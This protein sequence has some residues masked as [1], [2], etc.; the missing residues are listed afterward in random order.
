MPM[1][2]RLSRVSFAEQSAKDS[3]ATAGQFRVGVSTG[4]I[5]QFGT[6]NNPLPSTWD[7]RITDATERTQAMP[8]GAFTVITMK[9]TIGAI[10][11]GL[12]GSHAVAGADPY[13]HTFSLANTLPYY[14]IFAEYDIGGQAE[15]H[16]MEN[17]KF[18]SGEF[19]WAERGA[20]MCALDVMGSAISFDQGP[21]SPTDERSSGGYFK[22]VGGSLN[23]DGASARVKSGGITIANELTEVIDGTKVLPDDVFEGM[24]GINVS[25]TVVPDNMDLWRKHLTGSASGTSVQDTPYEGSLDVTFADVETTTYSLRFDIDKMPFMAA[26]PASDPSGG[27]AEIVVEG[28]AIGDDNSSAISVVLINDE[29]DYTS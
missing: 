7:S 21:G 27:P 19:S 10:L 16:R 22:S 26:F 28:V 6:D 1:N 14:S 18:N 29:S 15:Q 11:K 17:M 12:L 25:L 9:K 20:L 23:I 5:I 24:V 8:H 3:A 2:R 4:N 13:T